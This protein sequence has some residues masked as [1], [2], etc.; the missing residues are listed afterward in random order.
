VLGGALLAYLLGPRLLPAPD[1]RLADRPPLPLLADARLGERLAAALGA[2]RDGRGGAAS[3]ARGHV[4]A[5][6]PVLPRRQPL[7]EKE[8]QWLEWRSR[9]DALLRGQRPDGGSAAA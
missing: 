4:G 2:A 6:A 3:A 1:G 5:G 7:S 9:Q 8:A